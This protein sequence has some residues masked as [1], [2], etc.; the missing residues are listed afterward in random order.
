MSVNFSNQQILVL[1]AGVTGSAVAH[2]LGN[3]GALVVIADD[4]DPSAIRPEAI[5]VSKFDAAVVSPGWRL[6]HPLLLKLI[7]AGCNC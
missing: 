1:G 6:D 7:A 4:N 3:R 5:D 2:S